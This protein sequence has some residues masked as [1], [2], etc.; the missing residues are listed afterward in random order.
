MHRSCSSTGMVPWHNHRHFRKPTGSANWDMFRAHFWRRALHRS[1][2]RS[3]P[4]HPC[5]HSLSTHTRRMLASFRRS[6]NISN[7]AGHFRN[8]C[9][10]VCHRWLFRLFY[11]LT[12]LVMRTFL[13]YISLSFFS[14]Y[15]IIPVRDMPPHSIVKNHLR[16]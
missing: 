9:F 2:T 12:T 4:N 1:L 15:I 8:L 16:Q 14:L 13:T 11:F 6:V 3:H 7:Y 10:C 5:V